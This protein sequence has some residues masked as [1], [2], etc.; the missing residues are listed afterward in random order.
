[1]PEPITLAVVSGALLTEG[2]KFLYSQAGDILKRWRE[3]REAAGQGK[4]ESQEGAEP[5][6]TQFPPIFEGALTHPVIHFDAVE[7]AEGELRDLRRALADYAEG[8]ENIDHNDKELLE[9][10]DALRRILEVVYRQRI[11]FKGEQRAA[12]GPLVEGEVD[13]DQVTGY[14]AAVRAR[15]IESGQISGRLRATRVEAGGSAIGVDLDTIG[16]PGPAVTGRDP[17]G[18]GGNTDRT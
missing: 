16:G 2:V 13:V 15:A 10:T 12:S 11:T 8:I 17:Q 7:R 6:G 5:L 14:A 9:T 18:G 3:R 4:A 1:M